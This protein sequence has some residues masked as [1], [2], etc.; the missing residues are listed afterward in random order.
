MIQSMNNQ[1]GF[2]LVEVLVAVLVFGLLA[3]IT[4]GGLN[5]LAQV[6]GEQQQRATEF[7]DLQRVIAALDRDLRQLAS[8]PVRRPDNSVAPALVGGGSSLIA[9]RAGWANPGD[10]RRSQLQ[11]F[12][13]RLQGVVAERRLVRRYW[14]VTDAAADTS[15]IINLQSSGIQ[16]LSFRY[17]D[18]SGRWHARW[19][20]DAQTATVPSAIEYRLQSE[21]FGQI[22]RLLLL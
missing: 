8:R 11:R 14:P 15:G 20:A 7:A 22:R 6:S 19:P 9:T 5:A 17:R 13:W 2:T 21:R 18:G 4:Y 1:H 12:E 10:Q 16:A 3:A